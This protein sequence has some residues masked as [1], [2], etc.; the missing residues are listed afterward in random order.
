MLILF[1]GVLSGFWAGLIGLWK[2]RRGPARS[3]MAIGVILGTIGP[4]CL[5]AMPWIFMDSRSGSSGYP[6]IQIFR[7]IGGLLVPVGLVLFSVG[8]ALHGFAV[9]RLASRAEELE[10]LTVAMPEEINRLREGGPVA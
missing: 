4:I 5:F 10:Q 2:F 1:L 8:F 3:L 6:A 9:A 7:M